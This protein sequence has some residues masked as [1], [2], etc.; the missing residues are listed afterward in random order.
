M[1]VAAYPRIVRMFP[2]VMVGYLLAVV[3]LEASGRVGLNEAATLLVLPALAWAAVRAPAVLLVGFVAI[4]PGV[5]TSL[6]RVSVGPLTL[7]MAAT[8]A[9]FLV[10]RGV[11][12]RGLV[13]TAIPIGV[14]VVGAFTMFNAIRPGPQSAATEF[15]RVMLFYLVLLV[16]S[17]ALGRAGAI[18]L[19]H[20][21]TAILVSAGISGIIFLSQLGF[22]PW[23]FSVSDPS[24]EP[25][26]LFFRTHFGYMMALGFAVAL[27][28]TMS[29]A[30]GK[31]RTSDL[32]VLGYFSLLVT[33]SF[34]RGAWLVAL[35]LITIAPLRTGRTGL[36]LLLPVL[37]LVATGIPL[38]QERLFS[39]LSGGL[40]RSLESGDFATGRWGLWR[41]MADRAIAGFPWGNGYGYVWNLRPEALFARGASFTTESNPFV[42]VHNDFLYWMV[43]LGVIGLAAMV[44]LWAQVLSALQRIRY[45]AT[46]IHGETAFVGGIVLT[47][48]VASM[49]DNG[50][51]IRPVAERFFICVGIAM[52]LAHRTQEAAPDEKSVA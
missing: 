37:A 12:T 14:L 29:R 4:P 8:L 43:E 6:P 3:A 10:L 15:R 24:L 17:Y 25:G 16:L 42:Y 20:V 36:W 41:E 51:F 28:R 22:Q 39:D 26:G 11:V 49:V 47:M 38:I 45:A 30:P 52:A 46:R 33:F 27:S 9:A 44:A 31:I 34:T 7:L 18:K 50:L 32:V 5:L 1:S 2:L 21:G 48:F 35:V 23:N 13:Q 40:Q 19:A